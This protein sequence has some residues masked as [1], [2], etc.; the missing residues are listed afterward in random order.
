MQSTPTTP[1]S[2]HFL[3]PHG[4]DGLRV[5]F[6]DDTQFEFR[7]EDFE[8]LPQWCLRLHDTSYYVFIYPCGCMELVPIGILQE[9]RQTGE[10]P[11]NKTHRM[12]CQ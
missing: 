2:E 12:R 5:V 6:L 11:K 4:K 10:V 8:I 1:P 9:I 3:T 7:L